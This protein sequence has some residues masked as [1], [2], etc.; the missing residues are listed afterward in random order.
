[1]LQGQ[2]HNRG[3]D[4]SAY[5]FLCKLSGVCVRLTDQTVRQDFFVQ[6]AKAAKQ[7]LID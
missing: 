7:A 2:R 1:M 6:A 4:N 5:H 3:I